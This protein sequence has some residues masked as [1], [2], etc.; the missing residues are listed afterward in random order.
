M[1]KE[2][3]INRL[4]AQTDTIKAHVNRLKKSSY[5]VHFLDV[6][7][8][9]KKTIE[10][11]EL[12]FKL[13]QH[14]DDNAISDKK[15][16]PVSENLITEAEINHE[17][18]VVIKE[19]ETIEKKE[20]TK[21]PE[22]ADPVVPVDPEPV[23]EQVIV[24]TPST[25]EELETKITEPVVTADP[26][27]VSEPTI[28]QS[29]P[30][31]EVLETI[32]PDSVISPATSDEKET[33]A[34]VDDISENEEMDQIQPQQTTY[35]LFSG[36]TV[37]PV[38]EKFQVSE[39]HSIAERMQKSSITNIREAIG[40][41]EKFLFIN[42]LFNG[43]LGRYN[44]ILDDIN[45]LPTKKGVDTYLLELKIQFQ[46]ADENEAFIKL[47]DLLDRKFN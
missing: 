22:I 15:D 31:E 2:K 38:G 7:M 10:F 28:I 41:N 42:E 43:D 9:K 18:P 16:E 32:I 37:S 34:I 40:I 25:E 6:D 35:D 44:K 8:L 33:E 14:I 4:S 36:N 45:E 1:D 12:V 23:V 29:P 3:I 39:E 19:T 27:P 20:V 11:Y 47:K 13:E 5:S 17:D 46:W 30:K 26:V 21:E 24:Q